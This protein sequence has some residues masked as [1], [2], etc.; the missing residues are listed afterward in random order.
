MRSPPE[1]QAR[2][3]SP[4]TSKLLEHSGLEDSSLNRG[5]PSRKQG[6]S[7]LSGRQGETEGLQRDNRK[8]VA[9]IDQRSGQ[10]PG[11]FPFRRSRTKTLAHAGAIDDVGELDLSFRGHRTRD[12]LNSWFMALE[13]G[14]SFAQSRGLLGEVVYDLVSEGLGVDTTV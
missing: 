4:K 2:A 6:D 7:V 13:G 5:M 1:E 8:P 12:R 11:F 3:L 9:T 10:Q 14:D